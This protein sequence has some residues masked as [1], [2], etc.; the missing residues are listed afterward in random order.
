M[1]KD[2]FCSRSWQVYIDGSPCTNVVHTLGA[3]EKELTCLSPAITRTTVAAIDVTTKI[4][5]SGRP[6]FRF[7]AGYFKAIVIPPPPLLK[8]LA[9]GVP[10]IAYFSY[11]SSKKVSEGKGVVFCR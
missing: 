9:N 8:R 6:T 7:V 1:L 3:E 5:V 4:S 10:G 2:A 11:D